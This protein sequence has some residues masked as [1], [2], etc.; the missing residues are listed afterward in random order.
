MDLVLFLENAYNI[1]KHFWMELVLR[2][3]N[4]YCFKNI[5]GWT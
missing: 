3:G 1:K 5:F 4:A 2:L